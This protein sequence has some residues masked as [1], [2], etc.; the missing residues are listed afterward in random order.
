E[1]LEEKKHEYL[2]GMMM[3]RGDKREQV[4]YD[5]WG[6]DI[7]EAGDPFF[8]F[9]FACK[10]SHIDILHTDEF[11]NYHLENSFEK[12]TEKYFRYL[13]L[14]FRSYEHLINP[15]IIET[16]KEWIT[17]SEKQNTQPEPE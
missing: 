4:Y 7:V 3:Q 13:T 14:V 17:A 16:A 11:L 8:P 12:D 5:V 1:L 6:Q 9:F 15:A 10:L 2:P